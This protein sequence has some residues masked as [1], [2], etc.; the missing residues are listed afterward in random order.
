MQLDLVR[1]GALKVLLERA[2]TSGADNGDIRAS[3]A[4]LQNVASNGS[5]MAQLVVPK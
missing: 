2:A 4:C 3:L 1:M 5:N